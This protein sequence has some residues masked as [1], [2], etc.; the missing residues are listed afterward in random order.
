MRILVVDTEQPF[1][2]RFIVL[3]YLIFAFISFIKNLCIQV[4]RKYERIALRIWESRDYF[5]LEQ[6][7][8]E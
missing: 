8:F 1:N 5:P 6:K 3:T 2:L 4:Y 7:H